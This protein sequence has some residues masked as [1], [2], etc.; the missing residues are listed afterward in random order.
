MSRTPISPDDPLL[1]HLTEGGAADL[2]IADGDDR[3]RAANVY[4]TADDMPKE[5]KSV[6]LPAF[7]VRAAENVGHP[8]GFSG[9]VR[10]ALDAW[11]RADNAVPADELAQARAALVTLDRFLGHHRPAAGGA[12]A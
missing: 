2:V 3:V 11:L 7:M 1:G 4:D 10:E 12:A 5:V 8:D 6:R 9:V